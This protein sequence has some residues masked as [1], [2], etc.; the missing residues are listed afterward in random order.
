MHITKLYVSGFKSLVDFHLDLAPFTCLIGLNGCGKSTV[1]QCFDFLAHLLGGDIDEWFKERE[2]GIDD[3]R[4]LPNG[5]VQI[6]FKVEFSDESEWSGIYSIVEQ[7]C[8]S[9]FIHTPTG[10]TIKLQEGELSGSA[11]DS[12]FP[13]GVPKS[14]NTT[15]EDFVYRGSITNLLRDEALP[16]SI[17]KIRQFFRGIHA[18]DTFSAQFLRRRERGFRESVGHRGEYLSAFLA[19]LSDEKREKIYANLLDDFYPQLKDLRVESDAG[20]WKEITIHEFDKPHALTTPS[21]HINDGF[22]RLLA[23][24]SELQSDH[25]FLLFDEIENGVNPELMEKLINRLTTS[26]HQILV[27]THSPMILNYLDDDTARESVVFLYKGEDGRTRSTRFFEIPAL[28][29]KLEVMGPGEAFIDTNLVNLS[30]MLST[31]A[32]EN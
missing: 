12:E 5:W 27:T 31:E 2:W 21:K 23:I 30:R 4:N 8:V 32:G 7:K 6:E 9:E 20:G 22:L 11:S 24:L 13:N 25:S 26:S 29:D 1:L 10:A 14:L 28:D 15:T 19:G 17:L 16:S 18:F 3:L